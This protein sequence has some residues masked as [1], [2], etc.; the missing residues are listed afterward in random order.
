MD[1]V[2]DRRDSQPVHG[3]NRC[4]GGEACLAAAVRRI[5]SRRY[6]RRRAIALTIRAAAISSNA[7][8]R[9]GGAAGGYC[10]TGM[11]G[12]GARSAGRGLSERKN[13]AK[14][15]NGLLSAL[16]S[17]VCAVC[18]GCACAAST[19]A[20]GCDLISTVVG[21]ASGGGACGAAT[22]VVFAG[23]GARIAVGA[24]P[25]AG[26]DIGAGSS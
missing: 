9:R 17:S 3:L 20:I 12:R 25:A 18:A 22:G 21:G 13:L 23:L 15:E 11:G 26:A 5:L 7:I 19:P 8:P 4:D 14:A 1:D 16:L 24:A 6:S 2:D 10:P